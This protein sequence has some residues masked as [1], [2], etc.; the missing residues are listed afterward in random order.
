M[1][2]VANR[3]GVSTP[4]SPSTVTRLYT[5]HKGPYDGITWERRT[6]T[7][8]RDNA[9]DF[10]MEG[11][12]VPSTW[13]Q[14][15]T[16]I[17]ASK[18]FRKRGVGSPS[19]SEHSARQVIDRIAKAIRAAGEQRKYFDSPED[20][21]AFEDELTYMMIRQ[22]GAFNSPVWFNCG[23]FESYGLSG[24]GSGRWAIDE[25]GTAVEMDN[26]Y[27]RPGVSACF[28]QSIEDDLMDIAEHTKREMRVFKA[29]GGSGTNY[30]S[31][32]GEGE[33]LSGGGTSSGLMS[34]LKIFDSA[35]GATKSGGTTRRAARMVV[36]ND[37][38]PD[39]VNF[40]RWKAKEEDKLAA[41]V[42]QGYDPDFNG[43]AARTIGGQN[44]NNSVR[45][46][47]EFM[48]AVESDGDW[49]TR[50]RTDGRVHKTYKAREI[51]REIAVAA[52]RCADPG[53]QFHDTCNE[54]NTVA[55]T[56]VINSTNPCSEFSFVDN[57]S[58][59]LASLNLVRFLTNDGQFDTSSFEH[60]CRVFITA[61]E[62]LVDHAS[63]PTEIITRRSHELRPLGLG[64]SNLGALLMQMG[65]PYDSD[66]GRS[67]GGAITALM[68]GTAWNQSARLAEKMGPFTGFAHNRS[69]MLH[70]G[71]MHRNAVDS[72]IGP[73]PDHLNIKNAATTAW[74]KALEAGEAHGY[75]NAQLTV[76][77]PTGTISFVMDCDTFGV[78]PD[79]ALV[80]YKKLA[81][82][83]TFKIVNQSIAPTLRRLGYTNTQITT[84]EQF[85]QEHETVEGSPEI[86]DEHLPI[87]D[88]ANRC[89]PDGKRFIRPMAHLEM[90]SVAQPFLCGAIS[91]TVNLPE[92]TSVEEIEDIY[93]RSWKMGLK[94]VALYRDNSKGCQVLNASKAAQGEKV[95]E[96]PSYV[97]H[98]QRLPKKRS[99]ST[100]EAT[101]GGH[102][103]FL[104][105]GE[106]AD[107]RLGEIFID[108]QKEGAPLRAWADCF[109]IAVSLG[110]QYGVPLQ[111]FVDAYTFAKFEP[112]GMVRGH[113]H[114]KTAMSVPDYIFRSLAIDYLHQIDLAH[115]HPDKDQEEPKSKVAKAIETMHGSHK[116]NGKMSAGEMATTSGCS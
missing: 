68:C 47:D 100:Q 34:F 116:S 109:A 94:A 83:G 112:A 37:D 19:G 50:R 6:A 54:W 7:I 60:A 5:A 40:I 66:A 69:Q 13:S 48:R 4:V 57:T 18:Y 73:M 26:D 61:Q 25:A 77:A 8:K 114:V 10:E 58:C 2:P 79:F 102:K 67:V 11:V 45:A 31:I 97:A 101:V 93:T 86:K 36:V 38:H 98:R 78:E 104:R 15:A 111:E 72:A 29:G 107:G 23:L 20:A 74:N 82:G 75:R 87:F 17:I 56:D 80:K 33:P 44:S 21:Q 63:Y 99:G 91:K 81:G 108:M 115:V 3:S 53:M 1:S 70:V 76:L 96:E 105:T 110:L 89:G 113:D 28:I 30:S 64:Y 39:I 71:K 35:A 92:E 49:A 106:Y 55:Q 32:R 59:N 46:T 41:L 51:M 16:D 27:E 84:I 62:I 14:R 24:S 43:E 12:E 88:C 95:E 42:R 90:M 52:H 103:V 85:V 9:P 22:I 65:Y